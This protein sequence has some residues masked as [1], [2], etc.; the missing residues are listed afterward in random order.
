MLVTVGEVRPS[1]Q[2]I[3]KVLLSKLKET[4]G[5]D[6]GPATAESDIGN[7]SDIF[8]PGIRPFRRYLGAF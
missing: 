2:R 8:P 5:E 4:T 7:I 3:R 1:S 6:L